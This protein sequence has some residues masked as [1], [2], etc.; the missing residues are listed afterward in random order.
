MHTADHKIARYYMLACP[1]CLL[2]GA[3]VKTQEH[4]I[5]Q[6][7]YSKIVLDQI[8][9]WMDI[10]TVVQ[11]LSRLIKWISNYR[12]SKFQKVTCNAKVYGVWYVDSRWNLKVPTV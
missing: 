4:F 6:C 9:T 8:K 10:H 1:D 11:D 3:V 5:F 2:C 7:S 12:R